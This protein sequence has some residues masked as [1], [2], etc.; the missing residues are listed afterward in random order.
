MELV[1]VYTGVGEITIG[2]QSVEKLHCFMKG[3]FMCTEKSLSL[4][5]HKEHTKNVVK[6]A[7]PVASLHTR[8]IFE[9]YTCL[10]TTGAG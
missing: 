7:T 2:I 9:G 8:I 10:A 3:N 6:P 5:N 1:Q 4:I